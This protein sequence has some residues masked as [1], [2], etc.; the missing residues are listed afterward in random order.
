MKN[1]IK[2]GL[3]SKRQEY[4]KQKIN[5]DFQIV[6]YIAVNPPILRRAV[7]LQCLKKMLK[8]SLCSSRIGS[9]K[10][11]KKT[12]YQISPILHICRFPAISIGKAHPLSKEAIRTEK[13]TAILGLKSNS[14]VFHCT[15]NIWTL[16]ILQHQQQHRQNQMIIFI[17]SQTQKKA[18]HA[19]N[20]YFKMLAIR[21]MFKVVRRILW[22]TC[23][24]HSN[25]HY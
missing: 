23:D 16:R 21:P 5:L 2:N 24:Q 15:R 11:I 18:S 13:V 19:K 1:Q 8:D 6:N 12:V 14:L 25:N 9:L 20:C 7:L 17:K 4:Y 10:A 3:L 22:P